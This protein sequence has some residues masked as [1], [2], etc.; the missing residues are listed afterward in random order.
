MIAVWFR[1]DL[2]TTD[3]PALGRAYELSEQL[4]LPIVAVYISSSSQWEQHGMGHA[5]VDFEC[6]SVAALSL[7]LAAL[8]IPLKLIDIPL[9]AGIPAELLAWCANHAVTHVLVNRQYEWNE[10]ERDRACHRQLRR[11]GLAIEWFHDQCLVAP[12]HLKNQSGGFFTVFTPYKKRL[13]K[14]V[15]DQPIGVLPVL[16][17]TQIHSNVDADSVPEQFGAYVPT[18]HLHEG[19][20]AGEQAATA[21]LLAFSSEVIADYKE[22]RDFPSKP[23]TSRLAAYLAVGAIS[24]RQC[25]LA[26]THAGDV[27]TMRDGVAAWQNELIWRDFYRHVMVGYPRIS[28]NQPFQLKTQH[29]QWRNDRS[30]FKAWCEG[31][32]GFP[33]V[34]AAMRCLNATGWMHNR[35]RMVVAMFLVKDLLIDWRWGELYF[36]N[37]LID[38]D[39]ASNNGGWQWSASTGTDAVPYFRI[40]NPVLQS[41]KFDPEGDFIRQ[42]IPEL[43]HCTQAQI[44]QP[45]PFDAPNYVRPI[46]DHKQARGL[47][48]AAFKAIQSHPSM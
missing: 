8:N 38:F 48:L 46:V 13:F 42:W 5:R 4:Q 9:Y 30:E 28:R 36:A 47:A 23:A 44:H 37:Q 32:T 27:Q 22:H 17:P 25:W 16:K 40:F 10:V 31:Q 20:P 15:L 39:L 2:R 6:R 43:R 3:N 29:I 12:D 7:S 45:L 26:L 19:W 21:R 14:H 33:L 11:A 24:V 18:P 41:Q 1:A 34:D 35:L